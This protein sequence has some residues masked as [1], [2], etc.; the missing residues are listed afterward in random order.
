MSSAFGEEPEKYSEPSLAEKKLYYYGFPTNPLLV[1]RTGAK[2]ALPANPHDKLQPKAMGNVGVSHPLV[3]IWESLLDDL[4]E[5]LEPL[6]WTSID[7]LRVGYQNMAD[8]DWPVTL[9]I[10][11]KPGSDDWAVAS[12]VAV[13]CRAVLRARGVYDVECEVR[14]SDTHFCVSDRLSTADEMVGWVD[15]ELG[16]SECVSQSISPLS[17][18]GRRGTLG[19]YLK[20]GAESVVC[21]LTCRHVVFGMLETESALKQAITDAGV[22]RGVAQ[23]GQ[24]AFD[25][26]MAAETTIALYNG[27]ESAFFKKISAQQKL[28]DRRIGHVFFSPA[29]VTDDENWLHDW[30]LVKLEA[31]RYANL[32]ALQNWFW[33]LRSDFVLMLQHLRGKVKPE[34]KAGAGG[35]V[36][37]LK[38]IVSKAEIYQITAHDE[39]TQ[40][41][42]ALWVHMLF[43]RKGTIST[44]I[45]N[46]VRSVRRLK[47][48][49]D[50]NRIITTREWCVVGRNNQDGD[51]LHGVD[52]QGVRLSPFSASG[53]SG[54]AVF[55]SQG[56]IAG[57]LTAGCGFHENMANGTNNASRYSDISY[58]TPIEVILDALRAR[59]GRVEIL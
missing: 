42:A 1:A 50:N 56:R 44:G 34:T 48:A 38:D 33:V 7:L 55:D 20:V 31:E 52:S 58:V 28:E 18:P 35:N 22:H 12:R 8:K 36:V 10:G 26:V 30:L 24:V 11:V 19:I 15:N 9:M 46:E 45:S 14:Q 2:W 17:A 13:A 16:F 5:V 54:S 43:G 41:H 3:R 53:S 47:A 59:Y 27:E 40:D 25:K 51:I 29:R 23:P 4:M 37:R 39:P 6:A 57:I 32:S 49:R 21:A